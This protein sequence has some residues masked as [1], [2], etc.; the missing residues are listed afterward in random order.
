[1]V[2]Y[3]RRFIKDFSKI[4]SPLTNLTRKNQ[5]FVWTEKCEQA[6]IKIKEALVNAPVLRVL[7]GNEDLIVYTDASGS[8]LGAVLM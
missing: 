7:E 5:A 1:M 8:G 2:G 4:S 3:Y 6:F